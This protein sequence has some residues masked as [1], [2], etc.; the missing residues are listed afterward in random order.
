MRKSAGVEAV[1]SAVVSAAEHDVA[2]QIDGL[3]TIHIDVGLAWGIP[4]GNSAQSGTGRKA[5]ASIF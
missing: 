1:S 5:H 2:C 3:T 4:V